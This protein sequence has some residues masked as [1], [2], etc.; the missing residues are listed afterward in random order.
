MKRLITALD[1]ALASIEHESAD[2][3]IASMIKRVI[4]TYIVELKMRAPTDKLVKKLVRKACDLKL[5]HDSV[6]QIIKIL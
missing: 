1:W 5:I 4:S 6:V 2:N 3:P